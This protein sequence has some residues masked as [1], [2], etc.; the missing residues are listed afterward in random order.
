[1]HA[2]TS[3]RRTSAVFAAHP[4]A[5]SASR[6]P[7][8]LADAPALALGRTARAAVADSHRDSLLARRRERAGADVARGGSRRADPLGDD[9]LDDHD[10]VTFL[11]AQPDLITGPHA[12][13]GLD[14]D[15]AD[16]DVPGP[17]GNGRSRTRPGQPHRP[18]PAAR[19]PSLIT[20]HP[21]TVMRYVPPGC[22][23]PDAFRSGPALSRRRGQ[24]RK[25][26]AQRPGERSTPPGTERHHPRQMRMFA[27][28]AAMYKYAALVV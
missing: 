26:S 14:P 15:P 10:P 5:G 21:A 3:V 23:Q 20:R 17:A 28:R 7:E 12:M 19:P 2:R 13:R 25:S 18:D 27:I 9:L 11:A 22:A 16:P 24:V 4:R 6:P 1:M 8:Q